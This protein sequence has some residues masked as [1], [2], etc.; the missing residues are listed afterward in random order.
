[1]TP[2][3]IVSFTSFTMM[4]G[5]LCLSIFEDRSFLWFSSLVLDRTLPLWGVTGCRMSLLVLNSI[6]FNIKRCSIPITLVVPLKVL[7]SDQKVIPKMDRK[8]FLC[9]VVPLSRQ[10]TLSH[11]HSLLS[12]IMESMEININLPRREKHLCSYTCIMYRTFQWWE[13]LIQ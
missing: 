4:P 6:G 9:Y 10:Q 13:Y 5:H 12:E 8:Q 11:K 3:P 1:M 7:W 2:L